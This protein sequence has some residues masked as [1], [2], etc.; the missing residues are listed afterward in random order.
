MQTCIDSR[1]SVRDMLASS[2]RLALA[3][4]I[5]SLAPAKAALTV[6]NKSE[7]TVKVAVGLFTGRDWSSR[8]WWSIAPKACA[9][10]VTGTLDAR[11]YYLFGSDGGPGSWEGSHGFCVASNGKFDIAGRSACAA[12][13]FERE[14]FFEIDTGSLAD[15]TQSLA[16]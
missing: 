13:G 8:G 16:D 6:C 15:Y 14:G 10:V 3:L 4:L 9:S 5:F 1:Q 11:Y 7:K 12:R 2:M